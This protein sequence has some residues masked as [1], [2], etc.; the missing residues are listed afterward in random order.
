[1]GRIMSVCALILFVV[2]VA[3]F[4]T[5]PSAEGHGKRCE[6]RITNI[7]KGQTFTPIL[8]ASHKRGVKIFEL[9]EPA[10]PELQWLAEDG[11]TEDLE[12]LLRDNTN[13]VRDVTNSGGLLGPGDSV[14]VDV[15][16]RGRYDRVSVAAML[17]PTNDAFMAVQGVRARK[18][19]KVTVRATAYDAGTE[20][21]DQLCASIPGPFCGGDKGA[22]SPEGGDVHV[23]NGIHGGVGDLDEAE[24]DWRN[25]VAQIEIRRRGGHDDNSSD[26]DSSDDDD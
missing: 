18:G 20:V 24:F 26:D 16:C 9:G 4:V 13:G 21:N 3:G 5:S 23:H 17:I 6:V 10:S 2:A 12:T 14:I 7:T 25:P 19:K 11:D 1:M 22:G 15:E 8:V